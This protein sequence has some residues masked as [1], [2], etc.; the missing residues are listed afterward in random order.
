MKGLT[1]VILNTHVHVHV[2]VFNSKSIT[3]VHYFILYT[4]TRY[5]YIKTRHTLMS[6]P[7]C[8]C[9]VC[10]VLVPLVG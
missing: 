7:F 5:M 9:S 10:L 4:C 6:S 8:T 2:P 1:A 3:I